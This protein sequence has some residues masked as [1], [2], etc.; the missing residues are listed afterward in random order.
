[1][2]A[3]LAIG[4]MDLFRSN[5]NVQ[6]R[7]MELEQEVLAGQITPH[8]AVRDLLTLFASRAKQTAKHKRLTV[9]RARRSKEDP[10]KSGGRA[11]FSGID[12]CILKIVWANKRRRS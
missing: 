3:D 9:R 7:I 10:L 1:M 11:V 4:L 8:A 2:R 5:P 6:E 12:P